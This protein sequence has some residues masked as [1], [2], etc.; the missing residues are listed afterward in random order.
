[1]ILD[2]LNFFIKGVLFNSNP[3]VQDST[4]KN[5]QGST[6]IADGTLENCKINGILRVGTGTTPVTSADYQLENK[7]TNVTTVTSTSNEEIIDNKVLKTFVHTLVYDG[8]EEISI[9][10]IG[11]EK[12][13]S[14]SN[15][16]T[17]SN[18]T[19]LL[20][21]EVLTEPIKV[22]PKET[23]TVSMTLEI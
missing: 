18:N 11:L 10:E 1:M 3:R 4:Q 21:R 9:S 23:F 13:V 15:N 8:T 20:A 16:Y 6:F 17:A 19:I 5:I 14:W 2:N 7:L 22:Q 12:T